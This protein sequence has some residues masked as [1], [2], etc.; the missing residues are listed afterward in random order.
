M[1]QAKNKA[2]KKSK[3]KKPGKKPAPVKK[4]ASPK[5]SPT[6]KALNSVELDIRRLQKERDK[7]L[8]RAVREQ[9]TRARSTIKQ[10][11]K[12]AQPVWRILGEGDSWIRY[13]CGFG[14]MHHL[15]WMLDKRAACVNIGASGATMAKMMKLPARQKLDNYL[16]HGIDGQPWDALVFS[17]GGNDFAGDE[18]VNWL[19]PYA[20]QTNPADAIDEPA[21]AGLLD[22]LATLYLQLGA[23]VS[24]LSP[25]TK[26][27]V[28]AY[29]F[30]TPD[31]RDV[32][33]AGPWL[34]PGFDDRKYLPIDLPFRTA[35]VRIMLTRFASMISSVSA[36]YPF[37]HL[38]PTQGTLPLGTSG[39]D[40][41]L[42]PTE[43]GFKAITRVL[44]QKLETTLP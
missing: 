6:E 42:H 15:A 31:G 32:P 22:H 1:A 12:N 19:L 7:L 20:G 5:A 38:V 36:I 18:F 26:V 35:V 41:E 24:S 17:G 43:D 21:F 27:F 37:I 40:N 11:N 2:K 44:I 23:L 33:F 8:T 10:A 30:A 13:T 28:C 34:K 29:D 14:L 4:A 9:D 3:A 16:R 25:S 39:W